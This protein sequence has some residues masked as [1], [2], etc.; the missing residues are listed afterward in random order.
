MKLMSIAAVA[1]LL[2]APSAAFAN[3]IG[4]GSFVTASAATPCILVLDESEPV[5]APA[6]G[7]KH[8]TVA[9]TQPAFGVGDAF[10]VYEHSMLIDPPRY[11]LPAVT[12]NWRYY[13]AKGHT[14]KVDAQSF[15][16]LDVIAEG[17]AVLI[18]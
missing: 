17:H 4:T 13:R 18:N 3:C 2:L 15:A 5:A 10:P 1:T 9:P 7:A 8:L 16:V 12:G 6:P 11:G 14:Y